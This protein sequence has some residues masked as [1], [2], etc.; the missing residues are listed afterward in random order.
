MAPLH[1]EPWELAVHR[2]VVHSSGIE[3][4]RVRWADD[5]M[6]WPK[7]KDGPWISLRELGGGAAVAWTEYHP[8]VYDFEALTVT[9][10]DGSRLVIAGH[11]L[12]TGDGPV[13]V[14]GA[15][16]PTGLA[17]GT[18]YW[19]IRTSAGLLSLATTF[20]DAVN[21]IAIS[22]VGGTFPF[23]IESTDA[24]RRAGHELKQ[25]TRENGVIEIGVQ[26]RGEGAM[27]LLRVARLKAQS[28]RA[29]GLLHAAN[30]GLVEMGA[31]QNV[32]AA[33]NA[34]TYEPR[35]SMTVRLSRSAEHVDSSTFIAS[36]DLES[37]IA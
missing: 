14:V 31:V 22:P 34:A 27:G 13:A 35:A 8:R 10:L 11:P 26:L 4:E 20:E 29:R 15:A 2:W 18:G 23:A 25:V 30:V 24:T 33:L 36:F 17:T 5:G 6:P 21:E 7:A 28:P 16:P 19:A 1:S 32:G 12:R 3:Q 37:D 9:A